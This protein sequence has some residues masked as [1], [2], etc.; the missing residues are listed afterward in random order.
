LIHP[1]IT[2]QD[3]HKALSTYT[4][5]FLVSKTLELVRTRFPEQPL[6]V[7]QTPATHPQH[8]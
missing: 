4:E 7:G 3:I 6:P 8:E 1:S 2:S 5:A